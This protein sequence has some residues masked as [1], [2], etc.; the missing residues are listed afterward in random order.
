MTSTI[1]GMPHTSTEPYV[2]VV[3]DLA[4]RLG[5]PT[6]ELPDETIAAGEAAWGAWV[7]DAGRAQ[8]VQA[9]GILTARVHRERRA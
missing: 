3:R 9:L 1:E 7:A 5:H 2:T 6:I 8:L 4:R